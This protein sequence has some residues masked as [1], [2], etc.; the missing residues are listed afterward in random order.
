MREMESR[1]DPKFT[2]GTSDE[3]DDVPDDIDDDDDEDL[4]NLFCPLTDQAGGPINAGQQ[5]LSA[6]SCRQVHSEI[7]ASVARIRSTLLLSSR[8]WRAAAGQQ[9]KAS[10][11]QDCPSA[12]RVGNHVRDLFL[13]YEQLMFNWLFT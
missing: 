6:S 10:E 9:R 12:A 4:R 3:S 13:L 7:M 1:R 5:H 8:T 2:I 11:S